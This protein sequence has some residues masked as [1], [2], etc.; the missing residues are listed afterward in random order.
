MGTRSLEYRT[1]CNHLVIDL[2]KD[3]QWLHE[4]HTDMSL[5]TYG[6]LGEFRIQVDQWRRAKGDVDL[7]LPLRVTHEIRNMVASCKTVQTLP[8]RQRNDVFLAAEGGYVNAW[9]LFVKYWL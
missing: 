2:T 1:M 9:G 7:L 6:Q 3:I 4:T 8:V 5:Q